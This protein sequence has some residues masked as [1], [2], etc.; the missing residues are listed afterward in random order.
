[1]CALTAALAVTLQS[2]PAMAAG[3]CKASFVIGLAWMWR[4]LRANPEPDSEVWRY[5]ER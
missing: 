5:R 4:I 3:T 1:M 2:N